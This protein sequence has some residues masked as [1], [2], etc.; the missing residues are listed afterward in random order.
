MSGPAD[1]VFV[2]GTGRSGTTVLADLLGRHSRFAGVPIECR[3][4]CNPTGL[5]D[6]VGGRATPEE[7]VRKLRTY[8]WHR[9]R[10]GSKPAS[11]GPA[12]RR[13]LVS[14][15]LALPARSRVIVPTGIAGRA[16]YGAFRARQRLGLGAGGD[17]ARVRGLHQIIGRDRFDKAVARFQ[18]AHERDLVQASRDLFYDL[19]APLRERSGKAALVEMSTFTIAAAPELARIFPEARFVHSIRDGRDSGVSKT[20]LREKAHHPTDA[21]TGIDFWA[22]RLRRADLGVKGLSTGEMERL[23][24]ISL[25]ELVWADRERTYVDLLEFVGVEDESDMREFFETRMTAEAANRGRW[26]DGLD[27]AEQREVTAHYEATLTRLEREDYHCAQ[28][29]RRTYERTLVSQP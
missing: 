5:A 25:D 29:L 22:D 24:L 27:T 18:E 2:G 17:E 8:W 23:H 4:H 6:V 7:F 26:R 20:L 13:G 9:V 19:L 1:L 21:I 11:P 10:V 28:L 16:R 12:G 14:R 15:A 3:F